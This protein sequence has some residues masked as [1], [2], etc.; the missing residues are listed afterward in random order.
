MTTLDSLREAR[1]LLRSEY[2]ARTGRPLIP[3]PASPSVVARLLQFAAV[4]VLIAAAAAT[5]L[6][7]RA[8]WFAALDLLPTL[9][10]VVGWLTT[11]FACAVAVSLFRSRPE[12]RARLESEVTKKA[13]E[14]VASEAAKKTAETIARE[15]T[16]EIA[17]GVAWEE[18]RA[19]GW[20]VINE[21]ASRV[22]LAET[23][24]FLTDEAVAARGSAEVVLIRGETIITKGT[25]ESGSLEITD[26]VFRSYDIF[27]IDAGAKWLLRGSPME[28]WR[29]RGEFLV[30]AKVFKGAVVEIRLAQKEEPGASARGTIQG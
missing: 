22:A 10:S 28:A 1:E 15:V 18:F 9:I 12:R 5:P 14:A 21:Q 13:T 8:G 17:R 24:R 7:F 11:G 3:A 16:R 30:M 26:S 19:I 23:R 20:S 6:L 27:P 29:L 2:E 25:V 4:L